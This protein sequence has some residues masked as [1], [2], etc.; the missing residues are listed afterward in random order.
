MIGTAEFLR[1]VEIFSLLDEAE[2][3][4]LVGRL[5]YHEIDAGHLLFQEGD[6]GSELFIVSSGKISV[7]VRLQNGVEQQ[8]AEFRAGD[9][10]GEMSIFEDA[11][12]SASCRIKEKA[13]LLSLHERD[14]K[15][16]SENHPQVA[17]KLMEKMLNITTMRLRNTSE[18]VSDM[19]EWGE[20]ARKR[21]ITDELTGVYNRRFLD[22]SIDGY[23]NSAK[24]AQKPL[25][26]VMIDLDRFREINERHG[27]QAGDIVIVQ[28]VSVFKGCLRERDIVARYG[29][30]EFTIILPETSLTEA[31]QV[32]E[33]IRAGVSRIS[34]TAGEGSTGAKETIR[35]TISQGVASYP[36][37]G[38][39]AGVIR[40]KADEALY[41]AKEEGR[42]RVVCAGISATQALSRPA[43]GGSVDRRNGQLI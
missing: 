39:D 40:A 21:A 18:F 16:L 43:E 42:D 17:I 27:H 19:V 24:S 13:L 14:F 26:L 34:V 32:A 22:D 11:T 29:G 1:K 7:T 5:H 8:I 31:C 28:A 12:R 30:D 41:R 6:E 3:E 23:F 33:K 38:A 20:E 35:V 10:F 4:A 9:F 15:R 36:D 25:S 2:L 37:H